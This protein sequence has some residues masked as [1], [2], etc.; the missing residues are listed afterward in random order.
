MHYMETLHMITSAG[1]RERG[2]NCNSQS[3][4]MATK[5][6]LLVIKIGNEK[7]NCIKCFV[8]NIASS[9]F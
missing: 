2:K 6:T 3:S 5:E 4:E 1:E 8:G 9:F 7:L